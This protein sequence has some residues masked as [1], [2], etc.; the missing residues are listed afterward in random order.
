VLIEANNEISAWAE[1]G[2][3]TAARQVQQVQQAA[4]TTAKRTAA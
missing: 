4:A 2:V 3:R 1:K